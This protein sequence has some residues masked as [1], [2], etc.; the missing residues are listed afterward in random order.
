M[1]GIPYEVWKHL[2][3]SYLK[4]QKKNKNLPGFDIIGCLTNVFN[5]IQLHGTDPSTNFSLGWMCPIYKKKDRSQI[6]NYRPITLLNTDYKTMTKALA[7]QLAFHIRSLVHPDQTG[8][9]PKRSIFDPI[10]LAKTMCDYADYMEEDGA[11][12][13]LDQ[14]KAYDKIDHQY[15]LDTLKTFNL[16]DRFI[17]TVANLYKHAY[18][19]VAINGVLSNAYRVT[20]GV[21]QGDPLSCLLF[22]LAIEPLACLL[23]TSPNLQGLTIPGTPT[24]T[25]IN[26]Y[27]DDTTIYLSADDRHEDLETAL[28][29]W[30]LASGAK[31]NLEKTEVIPIGTKPHRDRIIATR[32][33]HSLDQPLRDEIKI[34]PDGHAVR[35]LGAWIGNGL[36]DTMPWEPIIDKIKTK[37]TLWSKTHPSLDGKRLIIQMTI[38]GITQF[39]T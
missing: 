7:V 14:E 34:V 15:L 37:L 21:R 32:W 38:G 13:A 19:T 10:K 8:F 30:C 20:R 18:T 36:D 3:E 16:P 17:S 27:T 6:E 4:N 39:L 12:I 22:D 28:I 24:K 9:I 25:L 1:D 26:M 2:N 35:C 31:F 23:R 11:I 29:T 5:D 33:L